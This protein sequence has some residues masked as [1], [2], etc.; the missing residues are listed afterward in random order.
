MQKESLGK[1]V[2]I[3]SEKP[4]TKQ[5]QYLGIDRNSGGLYYWAPHI[6]FAANFE[7]LANI[8]SRFLESSPYLFDGDNIRAVEIHLVVAAEITI[9]KGDDK[10]IER[11]RL[12]DEI[13]KLTDKLN[14][15]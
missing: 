1:I 12:K 7:D 6:S 2:C 4:G 5:V 3:V 9:S 10:E 13:A 14:K 11:Q 8:S 15:L